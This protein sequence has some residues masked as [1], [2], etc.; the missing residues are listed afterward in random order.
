MTNAET[1][2]L[3]DRITHICAHLCGVS[4]RHVLAQL[5]EVEVPEGIVLGL[6]DLGGVLLVLRHCGQLA[7]YGGDGGQ[8]SRGEEHVGSLAQSVGEVAC[9]GTD[10]CGLVSHSGL[11]A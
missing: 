10:H 5:V 11:V 9:G 2:R 4:L 6:V 1:D 3:T 8:L 7:L